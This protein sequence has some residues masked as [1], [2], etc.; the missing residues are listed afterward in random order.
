MYDS[1]IAHDWLCISPSLDGNRSVRII[2]IP[3]Y[4]K[5]HFLSIITQKPEE[6]TYIIPFIVSSNQLADFSTSIPSMLGLHLASIGDNWEIYLNGTLLRREIHLDTSGFIITHCNYRDLLI[7]FPPS[8]LRTGSNY[9]LFH[10]IGD[11]ANPMVGLNSSSPYRI[12]NLDLLRLTTKTTFE[13]TLSIIYIFMGLYIFLINLSKTF[14]F[15][16]TFG[17]FSLILGI[18]F[19]CRSSILYQ[20]ISNSEL[21]FKIEI[22]SLFLILPTTIFF[23][24][25]FLTPEKIH[26]KINLGLYIL[27]GLFTL[28]GLIFP[29]AFGHDLVN[30]WGII[31]IFTSLYILGYILLWHFF[32]TLQKELNTK[33]DKIDTRTIIKKVKNVLLLTPIGNIL[34]GIIFLACTAVFD[35]FETIITHKNHVLS[36]Y[37]FLIFIFGSIIAIAHHYRNLLTRL[38]TTNHLLET[39]ISLINHSKLMA[40]RNEQV[41]YNIF[42][43]SID[44]IFLTDDQL[45]I[46][47]YNLGTAYYFTFNSKQ[48]SDKNTLFDILP[49]DND[50]K[51]KLKTTIAIYKH[52]VSCSFKQTVRIITPYNASK[53][54]LQSYTLHVDKLNYNESPLF[55]IRVVPIKTTLGFAR[56]HWSRGS[57][58]IDSSPEQADLL[59]QRIIT[60]LC[61]FITEQDSELI[62]TGI[63][64]MLLNAIVHGN[65]NDPQKK[66]F[67]KYIFTPRKVLIRITDQGNGFDHISIL[68]K[69]QLHDNIYLKNHQGIFITLGAFDYVTYNEIGNQVTLGKNV[70]N[71]ESEHET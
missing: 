18:Y 37:S 14:A 50:S 13:T 28:L 35:A 58:T 11:P 55:S 67:V 56:L 2:D 20:W 7:S 29:P 71:K 59:S 42:Y 61:Y 36:R 5:H 40:E 16:R 43:S 19:L 68:K 54:L 63:H 25:G 1:P 3:E 47:D 45:H 23:L 33:K 21:L 51:L 4:S 44:P 38:Q 69:V 6:F 53:H 49:M 57:Y 60:P 65:K 70:Y 31:S 30:L 17:L 64:E 46:I 22:S 9:L 26:Q 32:I 15:M 10:I 52:H 41:F 48:L 24:S 8:L 34:I 62:R 66:V 12:A 39:Q 27:Y